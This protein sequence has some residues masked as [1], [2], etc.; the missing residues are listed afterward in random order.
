MC[1][2]GF[3]LLT[4]CQG[5]GTGEEVPDGGTPVPVTL[6]VRCH[7]AST[8][9]TGIPESPE[10]DIEKIHSWWVVLVNQKGIVTNIISR[11]AGMTSYVEQEQ[12]ETKIPK[13]GTPSTP[14]PISRRQN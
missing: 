11:P 12:I 10:Y 5:E 9:A 7:S 8:R 3:L 4:A 6:G 1:G 13:G 2:L 14:L